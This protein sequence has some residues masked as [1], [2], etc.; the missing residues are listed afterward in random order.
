MVKISRSFAPAMD[1][2]AFT[3]ASLRSKESSIEPLT[4]SQLGP[5]FVER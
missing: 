5:A 2:M 4:E 1:P 3:I